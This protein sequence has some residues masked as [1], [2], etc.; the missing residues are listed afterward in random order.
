MHTKKKKN[1][2]CNKQIKRE[3]EG[4]YSNRSGGGGLGRNGNGIGGGGSPRA[5]GLIRGERTNG[6]EIVAGNHLLFLN[7]NVI[8]IITNL[9]LLLLLLF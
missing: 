9:L 8:I 1:S 6:L 3:R 5:S 2:K 4:F 7:V